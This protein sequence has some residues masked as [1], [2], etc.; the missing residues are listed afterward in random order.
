[1]KKIIILSAM[2]F[3]SFVAT[4]QTHVRVGDKNV[5]DYLNEVTLLNQEICG[6]QNSMTTDLEGIDQKIKATKKEIG[7]FNKRY[8]NLNSTEVIIIRDWNHEED[9]VKYALLS[10]Q[11]KQY[12]LLRSQTV[13]Q[14]SKH[15]NTLDSMKM[16]AM[17]N[18]VSSKT[19]NYMDGKTLSI[20]N[21]SYA[22]SLNNN[23]TAT[24]NVG[25]TSGS[26]D[27]VDSRGWLKGVVENNSTNRVVTMTFRGPAG[28]VYSIALNAGQK[29]YV[30]LPAGQYTVST[31]WGTYSTKANV[32]NINP[33]RLNNYKGESISWFSAYTPY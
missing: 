30:Y 23:Q 9:S 25:N 19:S 15:I 3:V 16:I 13:A 7:R 20:T 8:R 5:N 1:M 26:G 10:T 4:S 18:M 11:L 31:Q 28:F 24:I 21:G 17:S 22:Y 27:N 33:S 32:L 14:Y 12:Q 29:E 6:L 2:L